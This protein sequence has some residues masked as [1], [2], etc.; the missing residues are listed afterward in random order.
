MLLL[1]SNDDGIDAPGLGALARAAS[2]LGDVHVVAPMGERS[3]QSHALTMHEPL[4]VEERRPGWHACSGQP[5]DCVYLGVHELCGRRPDAVLSGIN[6]GANIGDDVHYSGTVGAAEEAAL[7]GIPAL[8]VSLVIEGRP[9][10]EHH[11]DAAAALALRV[12]RHLAHAPLPRR[13]FLNL[14]VP[15]RPLDQ[16]AG[17]A[18]ARLGR[19]QYAPL[20]AANRDPRGKPY[21]WV[22]GE[23]LAHDDTEGTDGYWY[24]RGYA[25]L[26]PLFPDLTHHAS[27]DVLRGWDLTADGAPG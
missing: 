18:V 14:N 9:S 2:G 6:R 12:L 4:R 1:L 25:T 24:Q 8:A 7:L 21:Y 5:A 15:D 13:V 20:V 16:I 19:R 17:I 23:P 26:T 11:Y 3:A 10:P 22:G 27:L